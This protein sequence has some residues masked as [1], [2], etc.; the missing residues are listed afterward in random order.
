MK[1]ILEN[2]NTQIIKFLSKI[3]IK[4]TLHLELHSIKKILIVAHLGIG[5][6]VFFMPVIRNLIVHLPGA[7]ITIVTHNRIIAD[8]II[9]HFP[10]TKVIEKNFQKIPL[11]KRLYLYNKIRKNNYDLFLTNFLGNKKEY[12]QLALICRIPYRI[13]HIYSS[14]LREGK[15]DFFFNFPVVIESTPYLN[16][17]LNLLSFFNFPEIDNSIFFNHRA[18]HTKRLDLFLGTETINKIVLIQPYSAGN[19]LKNYPG[20]LYI[21]LIYKIKQ[22]YQVEIIFIGSPEEKA[23]IETICKQ[24]NTSY[25][26]GAG[27]LNFNETVDLISK[28]SLFIGNDSGLAKISIALDIPTITIWGSSDYDRAHSWNAKS[29]DLFHKVECAPCTAAVG[30]AYNTFCTNKEKL[31]CFRSISVNSVMKNVDRLFTDNHGQ[32]LIRSYT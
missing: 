18:I 11:L 25:K 30:I 28:A 17:N 10:E 22:K 6:C 32:R 26:I 9:H 24:L 19:P 16:L 2:L 8:I 21:D 15:F 3:L 14:P 1:K 12:I 27:I 5:D 7:E 31:K 23:P 4:E 13:G 29:V 20:D